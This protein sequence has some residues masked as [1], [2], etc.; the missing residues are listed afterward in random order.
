MKFLVKHCLTIVSIIAFHITCRADDG[1]VP[2]SDPNQTLTI[3]RNRSGIEVELRLETGAFDPKAHR[4]ERRDRIVLIDGLQPIGTDGGAHP[5]LEFKKFE[6]RW[7]GRS[8]PV[9]ADM[10]R[11]IYNVGLQPTTSLYGDGHTVLLV[12]SDTGKSLLLFLPCGDAVKEGVWLTIDQEGAWHRYV[13]SE[14]V[15]PS[16]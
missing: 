2:K 16:R 8:I 7:N 9:K 4:I 3:T 1:D 15:S 6:V 14:S 11:C 5:F 12:L 13:A 10:F